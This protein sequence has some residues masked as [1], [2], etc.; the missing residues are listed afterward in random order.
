[1]PV[2]PGP[3]GTTGSQASPS[4]PMSPV[5]P[6]PDVA[7]D[8]AALRADPEMAGMF[9]ADVAEQTAA[10][11][12]G[13]LH[14][15]AAPDDPQHVNGVFRP[16]HTI[17]GNAAIVGVGT[18]REVAHAVEDLLDLCRS[19]ARVFGR[20]EAD[21]VLEAVDLLRAQSDDLRTRVEDGTGIDLDGR[22]QALLSV[23][24]AIAGGTAD[25]APVRSQPE[26]AVEGPDPSPRP[27]AT[28]VTSIK[29]DTAKLDN[30]IDMVGELVIAHA[31]L[32][33]DVAHPSGDLE[34]MN[35]NLAG[36]RRITGDLQRTAMSMRM[37][38][39]RQT[40]RK[41]V[42]LVRDLSRHSGKPITLALSGE[43]TELDRRIVEDLT[44]PLMHMI[45][46]SV[47]HGIEAAADRAARGKP[48]TGRIT[49]RAYHKG[50]SIVIEIQ[51]D[52]AGIDAGRL[53]A[54]AIERGLIGPQATPP[55]EE[56]YPLIFHPGFSTAE[57]VTEIS[58]R[59]VGMDVVRRNIELLRGR[60]EIHTRPGEGTTFVI[61]VPLTL[62][63][64]DGLILGVG[65]S[66]FVIP[67]F[68]VRESLR[69]RPEQ[70]RTVN[71]IPALIEIREALLPLVP[72][73]E[74]F[75]IDAPARP[76]SDAIV[77]VLEDDGQAIAL[78]VDALLGK[79]DVVIKSLGDAFGAMV[80]VAGGAILGDGRVGLILDAHGLVR[81]RRPELAQAA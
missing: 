23:I 48:A 70:I 75:R 24:A 35:R 8:V 57:R 63:I 33:E 50:G 15:E 58:G 10:I 49:L 47:D 73:S 30:L 56:L 60:I 25:D 7:A 14:L 64:L 9:F 27:P 42:R 29:V 51:D 38:P 26:A 5:P 54:R 67:T 65:A 4:D 1:M 34:R 32:Q 22:R 2:P 37:V 17:K 61:T 46:N 74:V 81:Q 55:P 66:R 20:A 77:V 18:V 44:D 71:G 59:G 13:V 43:D 16:F 78:V 41:M 76:V 36:I 53:R 6:P 31:I 21:V 40:F 3:S 79:Q 80:G 52:G 19:G 62:A 69:P 11:E 45:R 12:A 72:L 39:I 28:A 68:A